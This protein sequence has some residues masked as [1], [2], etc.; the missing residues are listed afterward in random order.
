MNKQNDGVAL[1]GRLFMSI[2][3]ITS[4]FGKVMAFSGASGYIASKG[5]PM[6]DVLAGLAI[7]AEL[8]GG[9][10]ILFGFKTRLVAWLLV[11]FM[12]IITPIFHNFWAAAAD[13]MGN[14]RIHFLKN[15]SILGGILMIAAFG[16]GRFSIDKG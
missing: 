15:V 13:Q 3:F 9:L 5:L 6:P 2:L 12:I 8:G 4:G 16:P 1:A 11:L 10:A 14:Q 7:I